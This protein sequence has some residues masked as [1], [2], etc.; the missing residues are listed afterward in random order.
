MCDPTGFRF[1]LIAGSSARGRIE[2][3]APGTVLMGGDCRVHWGSRLRAEFPVSCHIRLMSGGKVIAEEHADRLEW[4]VTGPGVYR[5][6][7]W[8]PLDGEERG[9]GVLEPDLHPPVREHVKSS[10]DRCFDL[11]WLG[12]CV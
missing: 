11:K 5:I 4:K 9:L 1:E 3:G 12:S 10:S 2:T 7:G 6:E 8:L